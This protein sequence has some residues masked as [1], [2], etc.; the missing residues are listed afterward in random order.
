MNP[1]IDD[2]CKFKTPYLD[3]LKTYQRE[4]TSNKHQTMG[5][6]QKSTLDVRHTTSTQG[7]YQ[8]ETPETDSET[9]QEQSLATI[10]GTSPNQSLPTVEESRRASSPGDNTKSSRLIDSILDTLTP[11]EREKIKAFVPGPTLTDQLVMAEE[12]ELERRLASC[13]LQPT[14]D[15]EASLADTSAPLIN[16]T[17]EERE[18]LLRLPRK[19]CRPILWL[20]DRCK[21]HSRV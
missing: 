1:M 8:E 20:F 18:Y 13:T 5:T 21:Y 16:F 14:F 15:D 17:Q 12:A 6:L 2:L 10:K 19:E 4:R 9:C 7:T 3:L 11:E